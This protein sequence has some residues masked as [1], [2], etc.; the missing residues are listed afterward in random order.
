M[1]LRTKLSLIMLIDILAM[2][3]LVGFLAFTGSK[4]VIE[5]LSRELLK[6]QTE[7]A[8]TLCSKYY[9]TYFE[10]TEELKR[11][12]AGVQIAGDGY[13]F[14]FNATQPRTDLV[15]HPSDVGANIGDFPHIKQ[16]LEEIE[17]NGRH[18]G[19]SNF[20]VYTQGTDAKNRQGERKIGY[21]VYFAPWNWVLMS[22]G[23][24]TDLYGRTEAVRHRV[25]E[26]IIIVGLISLVFVN[27]TIIRMFRPMRKLIAATK[28]VAAGNLDAKIEIDSKDEIGGLAQ[29]FNQM[30]SGLKENTRVWQELEIARRLQ[31]QM[32]PEGHPKLPGVQI[33]ARS[34]PATEVGGDFYDFIPLDEH[35]FALVIGDVSGKG[36]SGA[37]G[38]SSALSAIRFAADERD[39]TDDILALANRRL[40]RDIQRHMF[41]AVFLAIY[42]RRTHTLSYTNAGQTMP[43]IYRNGKAEF[44]TISEADRFPLGIRPEVTFAQLNI[45]MRSGD[46]LIC[47]TDGIIELSN[48][49]PGPYEPFGFDRFLESIERHATEPLPELLSGLIGDAEQ[50][51]GNNH[52]YTDDITLVLVKIT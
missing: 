32:L 23:Y 6:A 42:D 22:S 27:F 52:H 28:K 45:E 31:T 15:I 46:I 18:D 35:R 37:I 5:S 4:D 16:V 24:E 1:N 30:L 49:K 39:R 2:V 51:F 50:F 20:I 43:V 48:G 10:P 12:I 40:I 13:I 44:L 3:G 19:A 26:A 9:E 34:I 29:H 7:Y 36:I 17:E 41:V 33:E 21:Y 25:Y 11:T 8:Y 14:V 47:Y 38:M